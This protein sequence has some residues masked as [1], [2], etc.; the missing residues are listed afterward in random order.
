MAQDDSDLA[1]RLR[2]ARGGAFC[3]VL[4]VGSREPL[5]PALLAGLA[6]GLRHFAG[7]HERKYGQDGSAFKAEQRALLA[8]ADEAETA[9]E[10]DDSSRAAGLFSRAAAAVQDA[11]GGGLLVVVDEL[12]KLLEHAA[13]Y[14]ED[15]DLFVLQQL[16]ERAARAGEG[17]APLLLFTILHQAFERYAGRLSQTQREEWQ[18]VQGRFAD[19]AFVEPPTETL[20]LLARAVDVQDAALPEDGGRLAAATAALAAP[21]LGADADWLET[22]LAQALP[23]H[24]AV[25]L[26]V[27][28]LFRRLAQNER[29]LFAFLASGEQHGFLD[30]IGR[31]AKAD[32]FD[33]PAPLALYRLDHLYDYLVTHLGAALFSERMNRLWAETEAAVAALHEAGPLEVRLVKHAALLGFA[34]ALVGLPPTADVLALTS[35][36]PE[37]EARAALAALREARALA[38]RPFKDEYHVWQGSDFDLGARLEEARRH[39][40]LR[41]PLAELLTQTVPPAPLVARR[42]AYRTGTPRVFEVIYAS[43]QTWAATLAEPPET[44]DG[45]VVYV[46]PENERP[47]TL[48]DALQAGIDDPLTIA[49]VPDGVGALREAVR[50]L[51]CLD[52]VRQHAPELEGDAAARREL[53]EQR[54]ALAAEVDR[55]LH[56]LLGDGGQNPCTWIYGGEAFRLGG[57][58]ALQQKLSAVC[59]E[60]FARSPEVWNELLNRR[61]PSSSAVRGLKLLLEAMLNRADEPRLGIEGHPAE[62]GMYASVLQATG[63]HRQDGRGRWHFGRPDADAHPGCAAVWDAVADALRNADGQPVPIADLYRLLSAPPYGVRPGLVPVF[64]FA[65][66]QHARQEVAFYESGSFVRD[67]SFETVERLLKSQEKGQHT[68]SVQW[69]EITG[70]RAEVLG[71]LVP[72]LGLP[73]GTRQPLPVALRLLRHAHELSPFVRRTASL[74]ERTAAVRGALLRATDPKALLFEQLPEACGAGSFLAGAAADPERVTAFAEALQDALRELAGAYPALLADA[75]DRLARAFHLRAT[76]AEPR[77]RELAERSRSL[78]PVARQTRLKAFLVRATDEILATDRWYE[79]LAALLTRQPPAQWT[80]EDRQTYRVALHEVAAAFYKLEPLAYEVEQE[81]RAS[82]STPERSTTEPPGAVS[83]EESEPART[84][85]L[86]PVRFEGAAGIRRVRLL[87]KTL[88]ENEHDGIVHVHPEDGPLVGRLRDRLADALSH[89]RATPDVQ[90][91]ALGRLAAE[92]IEARTAASAPAPTASS[93]DRP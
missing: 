11:S 25:A 47:E 82:P 12:G 72:L 68:F 60:V 40:P 42:H 27:G 89:E 17:E 56:T 87:V 44:A 65:F 16:A 78:L 35:S 84:A 79:S 19:I 55:R 49:A 32:L 23:L 88:S 74:S 62:Y 85:P 91:A 15:G 90:L 92:L 83:S 39:V 46:L 45:R 59:D 54:A 4:V 67:L 26:L 10:Q 50:D 21:T 73:A 20:R 80:D 30:V 29:S 28:P 63:L 34:G 6:E 71:A 33:G 14:P 7:Q 51:A 13:L 2:S 1:E 22:H 3:P 37:D 57:E 70:A 66:A 53:A 69:V 8:L 76:E 81:E 41:T 48:V 75:Q 38:Y 5:A 58:R 86:D 31:E 9:R 43:D 77:R 24:P 61:R 52:W 18:K 36:A 64:L 93:S